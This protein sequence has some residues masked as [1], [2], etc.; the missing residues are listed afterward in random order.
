MA[1]LVDEL[2]FNCL[3]SLDHSVMNK[4]VQTEQANE[5]QNRDSRF[6]NFTVPATLGERAK[7]NSTSYPIQRASYRRER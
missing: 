5:G 4:L 6:A 2:E 1:D 3:W 7:R